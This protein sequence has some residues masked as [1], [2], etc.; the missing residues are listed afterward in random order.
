VEPPPRD[1]PEHWP[2]R[3]LPTHRSLGLSPLI[4]PIPD[5][6]ELPTA[7]NRSSRV[8]QTSLVGFTLS[9]IAPINA[10]FFDARGKVLAGA[11]GFLDADLPRGRTAVFEVN[12]FNIIPRKRIGSVRV[13]MDAERVP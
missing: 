11:N 1:I 13:T 12:A 2:R 10:V 3:A 7:C 4:G 6:H 9:Q 5:R 8:T